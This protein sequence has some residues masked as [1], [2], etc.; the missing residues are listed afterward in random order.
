MDSEHLFRA[1]TQVVKCFNNC[2][3]FCL[4]VYSEHF[5]RHTLLLCASSME[6]IPQKS[7]CSVTYNIR[8]LKTCMQT[9]NNTRTLIVEVDTGMTSVHSEGQSQEYYRDPKAKQ[10]AVM[11]HHR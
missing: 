2:I 8:S 5:I 10:M 9:Q 11:N 4:L 7:Q 6:T 3:S 1:A